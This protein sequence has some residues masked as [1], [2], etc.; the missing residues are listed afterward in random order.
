MWSLIPVDKYA[1]FVNGD[2]ELLKFKNDIV[3]CQQANMLFLPKFLSINNPHPDLIRYD[4]PSFCEVEYPWLEFT[5]TLR[6]EQVEMIAPFL[7]MYTASN[8]MHGC[9]K[10]R[11]GAG[12]TVMGIN[13]ACVMKKRCAIVINNTALYE[14]WIDAII[15]FTNCTREQIGTIQGSTFKVDNC[16]FIVIMVQTLTSKVKN[17]LSEFYSKMKE[18]GIGFVLFDECHHSTSGPKYALASL[19]FNT[20]NIVGLSATPFVSGLHQILM[21]NTVGPIVSDV[22]RYDMKPKVT[23]LKFN[24]GLGQKYYRSLSFL[25]D[26]IKQRAKYN[27]IITS[28]ESYIKLLIEL[29]G[30]FLNK[31]HR[32]LNI[33]FTKKQVNEVS[34]ALTKSGITNIKFFS[35]QRQ[36]DKTSDKN[37]VA[38]Y[39]FAGEGFDYKEL[40]ALIIAIPLSGRKSLI[41]VI[42]RI[43][44]QHSDK[45]PPEVIIFVD[46]SFGKMFTNDIPKIRGV[47]ETEFSCLI[48]ELSAQEYLNRNRS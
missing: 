47:I 18:L 19:L 29:N 25:G 4:D 41:Q 40:S 46:E 33:F 36:L 10:A 5:G 8:L 12:K 20:I 3:L 38:T 14:Q 2:N 11:P 31:G 9:L 16:P 39:Q 48:E 21:H 22:K 34:S 37:L 24:S 23:I 35:E 15:N 26:M 13:L 1:N 17:G 27:S 42:G 45:L 6:D 43:L 28:S 32:L 44:R 7:N 30:M